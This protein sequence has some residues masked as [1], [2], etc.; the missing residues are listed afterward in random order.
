MKGKHE[1][2]VLIVGAGPV[3][4]FTALL[5]AEHGVRVQIVD[6]QWRTGAHSYAL[7]LHPHSL[8]LLEQ[9]GLAAAVLEH[10]YRVRS[11][12][13]SDGAERRGDLPEPRRIGLA[14]AVAALRAVV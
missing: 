13:L 2:E 9:V 11:V 5:L 8:K 14:Y 1:T 6:E 7:A 12:A 4:L 10:G 3:G